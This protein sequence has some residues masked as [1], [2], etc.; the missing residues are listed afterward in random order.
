MST[1]IQNAD[2]YSNA[3]SSNSGR[4]II[5][6]T[7]TWCGPCKRIAPTYEGLATRFPEI[8]FYTV[9]VDKFRQVLASESASSIPFFS[10]YKNGVRIDTLSGANP[11][12][13]LVL[14]AELQKK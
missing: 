14:I 8:Q 13:L 9:D 6:L 4:V 7:A 1:E 12:K 11:D 2:D 10:T 3:I 5:R